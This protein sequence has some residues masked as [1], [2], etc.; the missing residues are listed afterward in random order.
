MEVVDQHL[1]R[2]AAAGALYRQRLCDRRRHQLR[3]VDRRERHEVDTIGELIHHIGRD[4]QA[5]PGLAGPAW[6]GQG[7]QSRSGEEHLRVS[8]LIVAPDKARQ[9]GRQI[10][11]GRLQCPQLRKLRGQAVD[12]E[13]KEALGA[14][15][16]FEAM[17]PQVFEGD[18]RRQSVIDQRMRG[19]RKD[20]LPAVSGA[21]DPGRSM[22]V[23]PE[24]FVAHQGSLAGVQADPH[25]HLPTV[26]PV[27]LGQRLLHRRRPHAGLH[28]AIEHDEEGIAFGAELVTAVRGERLALD[29]VMR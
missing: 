3:I 2:P 18:R 17:H 12:H 11:R 14:S 6:A 5:Q 7:E 27:V 22:D 16:I 26:R 29:V 24:V 8:Y 19:F 20:Y 15:Q 9:L 28:R 23:D 25:L 13:L 10:V 21:G 1:D 4:L